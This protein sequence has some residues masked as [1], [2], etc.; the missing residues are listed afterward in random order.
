MIFKLFDYQ[1]FQI[2]PNAES[3]HLKFFSTKCIFYHANSV[4]FRKVINKNRRPNGMTI[5]LFNK[6][7]NQKRTVLYSVGINVFVNAKWLSSV[8]CI[9]HYVALP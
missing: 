8:R 5:L 4:F 3:L 7:V 6:D 9:L 2:F 1:N